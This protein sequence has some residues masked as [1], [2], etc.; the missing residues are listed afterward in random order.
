MRSPRWTPETEAWLREHY[1]HGTIDDTAAEMTELFGM[2]YGRSCVA[3][4]ARKLGLSK[5]CDWMVKAQRPVRWGEH[6]DWLDWV[7]EHDDGTRQQL[8][9]AFE[10]EFGVRLT[11]QQVSEARRQLGTRVTRD[12]SGD[13]RSKALPLGTERDTGK[14]YVLVKVREHPDKPGTKD[15]WRPRHVLAYEKAYGPVPDGCQVMHADRDY[16]NDD[17]ANLVA[18]PKSLVG[19]VNQSGI[20]YHDRESL[21]AAL[22]IAKI[23]VRT[24]DLEC[25]PRRCRVCGKVFTPR[26]EVKRCQTCPECVA[27]GHRWSGRP[28]QGKAICAKCGK[29]FERYVARQRLCH[30]CSTAS[31]RRTK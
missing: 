30:D 12:W 1:A 2:E 7:R 10:Q 5:A 11:V 25:A 22:A 28:N 9:D 20:P 6:P 19:I 23:K 14:G 3:L 29:E 17:P 31:K 21:E 16:R 4:H 27:A 18:A 26:R 8:A 13:P 15:N 24:V